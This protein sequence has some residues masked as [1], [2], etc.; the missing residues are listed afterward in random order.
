MKRFWLFFA[1]VVTVLLAAYFV[2]AT[3]KPE[4]LGPA[5]NT[6]AG[7]SILEAPAAPAGV[8]P[9]GSFQTRSAKSIGRCGEYQC[10]QKCG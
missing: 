9:V 10:E 7:I 8:T 6:V 4:W 1:Q 2:V 5:R 3:L